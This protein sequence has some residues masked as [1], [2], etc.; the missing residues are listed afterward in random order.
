MCKRFA[1]DTIA[2]QRFV[3]PGNHQHPA[4]AGSEQGGVFTP[5]PSKFADGVV[6]CQFLLSN[7][8]SQSVEQPN[9]LRPLSQSGQYYPIFA[10]GLV[11]ATGT[12]L[13]DII[14]RIEE[15]M[16]VY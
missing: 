10:T 2:I 4:P 14:E 9:T 15:T 5:L 16:N 3:N 11:N 8:A 6:T 13:D 1:D 7:F 12:S